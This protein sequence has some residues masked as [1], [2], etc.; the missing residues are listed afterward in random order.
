MA[1]A[2]ATSPTAHASTPTPLE[3]ARGIVFQGVGWGDYLA[4]L[5][6]IGDRP[7]RVTYDRGTMEVWMPSHPHEL[8]AYNLGRMIDAIVE[9]REIPMKPG[10]ATTLRR[11]D[12][13]RGVEPDNCYW[14]GANADRM[15]GKLVLDLSTDPPPDLIIEVKVASSVL[16]R[17]PI[18]AGLGV[19]EIW[20]VVRGELRFLHLC[21]DLSY[22]YCN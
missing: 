15:L 13:D 11:E 17:L 14:L 18:F 8:D 16:P 3:L 19:P 5:K 6:I 21:K 1:T 9:A 10:R 20:R 7:I 12:L 22:F 2:T 4:Q